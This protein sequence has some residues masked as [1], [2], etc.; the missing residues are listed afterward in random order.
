MATKTSFGLIGVGGFGAHHLASIRRLEEEGRVH[1]IAVCD[2]AIHKIPEVEAELKAHGVRIYQDYQEMLTRET[3][4]E[5]V[6]IAAPSPF[7]DR[8]V[9]ACLSR[10]VFVYLE[11]PPIPLLSQLDALIAADTQQKVAVGFQWIE[12]NWS[13]RIKGWILEGKL[14][15]ILE[16]RTAACWPRSDSYYQRASWVGRMTLDDGEPVFDGPATNAFSHL[17]HNIMFFAASGSEKFAEPLEVQAELY[18]ARPVECYDTVCMRGIFA[19]GTRF[20]AALTHATEKPLP[21][22][23]EVIGS[24]GWARVSEDGQLMESHLG[25]F[26]NQEEFGDQIFRSFKS[27]LHYVRGETSRPSTLLR[28]SRGYSLATNAALL[29]SGGIHPIDDAWI[30]RTGENGEVIYSVEGL[31]EIIADSLHNPL[32]FSERALPW[33][34]KTPVVPASS[35]CTAVRFSH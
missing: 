28:D 7:H 1:L 17:I 14:G 22:Q 30:R 5:A 21:F 4:L 32:L 15:E 2:P 23:M 35:H 31:Q 16:I 25:S 6:S 20:F 26:P 3:K 10:G 11:K 12:S 18:R 24:M 13:Q 34:V 27:F 9:R 19:S 8:M 29:S 33:A